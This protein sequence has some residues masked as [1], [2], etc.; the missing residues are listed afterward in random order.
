MSSTALTLIDTII[1]E[2]DNHLNQDVINVIDV[3]DTHIH[4]WNINTCRR[5][6]LS[7]KGLEDI[8]TTFDINTY[9]SMYNNNPYINL[10]AGIFMETDVADDDIETEVKEITDLCENPTNNLKA[11]IMKIDPNKPNKEFSDLV[12]KYKSNQYIVGIRTVLFNNNWDNDTIPKQVIENFQIL[13]D[14]KW[15]YDICVN[16][17]SL[18]SIELLVKSVSSSMVFVLDHMANHHQINCND[19]LLKI[20]K[21]NIVKLSAYKNVCIKLSGLTTA[22]DTEKW[23]FDVERERIDFVIKTFDNCNIV[24]G[25]DWPVSAL[26]LQ[27]HERSLFL[28]KW[29]KN[30]YNH[31]K[32]KYGKELCDKVFVQNP[33]RIYNLS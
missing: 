4:L 17:E 18:P 3:I 6:W 30:L 21:E 8:N 14:M 15:V 5:E 7:T 13:S 29:T 27:K 12:N 31:L 2:I 23:T 24:T 16:I 33:M 20:W 32:Q 28:N 25:S 26:P 19:K 10:K 11:I 9:C 1:N 22:K